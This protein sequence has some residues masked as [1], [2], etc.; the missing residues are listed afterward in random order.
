MA[1]LLN[2]AAPGGSGDGVAWRRR[3][4]CRDADPLLFFPAAGGDALLQIAEAKSVCRR[5]P[6]RAECLAWA[7][8]PE[9]WQVIGVWGGMSEDE[10]R[11][12]R[13]R[14]AR[15]RADQGGEGR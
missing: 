8:A 11:A 1:V 10:R 14:E 9:S 2:A 13:R 4:A 6:V 5:C 12:L 7:T 15:R 3:A